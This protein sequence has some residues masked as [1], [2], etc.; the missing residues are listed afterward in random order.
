MI[1]VPLLEGTPLVSSRKDNMSTF[2]LHSKRT[3]ILKGK[4]VATFV[5]EQ[6]YKTFKKWWKNVC[7]S[8]KDE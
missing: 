4:H 8:M 1:K 7:N 5:D 3:L 6:S 2:K